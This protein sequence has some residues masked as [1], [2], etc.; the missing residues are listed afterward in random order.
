MF[1]V[2]GA[3]Y[4]DFFFNLGTLSSAEEHTHKRAIFSVD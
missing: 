2:S 3:M 1:S 4:E